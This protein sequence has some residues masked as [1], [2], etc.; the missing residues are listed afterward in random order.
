[1]TKNELLTK[2]KNEFLRIEDIPAEHLSYVK[3]LI[4]EKMILIGL[5]NYLEINDVDYNKLTKKPVERKDFNKDM[6]LLDKTFYVYYNEFKPL[7]IRIMVNHK[8][9]CFSKV[10][11]YDFSNK[12]MVTFEREIK[13]LVQ[14]EFSFLTKERN[15]RIV[16]INS[17][18]DPKLLKRNKSKVGLDV[19]RKIN[20]SSFK[21]VI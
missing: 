4:L 5:R 10:F 18:K 14:K 15:I 7:K 12:S 16:F 17:K 6:S 21:S 2:I 13:Q 11:E 19:S 20:H 1:M 8:P 3:K 9:K